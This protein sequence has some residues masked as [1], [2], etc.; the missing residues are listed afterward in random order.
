[1]TKVHCDVPCVDR[2]RVNAKTLPSRCTSASTRCD[3]MN[4]SDPVTRTR[5]PCQNVLSMCRF[6]RR[7]QALTEVSDVVSRGGTGVTVILLDPLG[8]AK[9]VFLFYVYDLV[10][11]LAGFFPLAKPK[12]V[13]GRTASR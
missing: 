9:T 7:Y 11:S 2:L 12:V 5:F 4:P 8:V 3:P 13:W 1:M 10:V 6:D